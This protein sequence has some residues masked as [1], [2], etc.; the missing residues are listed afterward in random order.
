[1]IT[2]LSINNI[3]GAL[4]VAGALTANAGASI[5]GGG[6]SVTGGSIDV[7]TAGQGLKVA[8]GSNAK[9]G[10]TAAMTAGV[11][12]TA[13]TSVTASS[14]IL[15]SQQ[16]GTLTGVVTCTRTAGTSFTLTSSANTD[17]ATF[18]YQIFEPG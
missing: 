15:F 3:P 12:T 4:T 7:A 1:M 2:Q 9:Q 17:T 10:V 5:T 8:E 16:S 18:A 14:R 13:D 6:L 11:V